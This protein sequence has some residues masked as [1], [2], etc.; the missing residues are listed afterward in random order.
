VAVLLSSTK[1]SLNCGKQNL[2]KYR[3]IDMDVDILKYENNNVIEA[4]TNK[5][6]IDESEAKEIF[7]QLLLW[8][9]YCKDERTKGYQSIDDATL[10]IDEMWHT[11]ILFT[12]SYMDFCDKYLGRYFH[13]Q[14]STKQDLATQRL[15]TLEEV[16]KYKREQYNLVYEILG[17]DTVIK[18]YY[19]YPEKYSIDKIIALLKP[20]Y[21]K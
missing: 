12:S 7:Q 3:E 10:I 21:T 15:R 4:F 11:F 1:E 13:H 19:D 17:R 2:D 6:F 14:P 8:I 16:R 9:S 5:F 20:P 18:W